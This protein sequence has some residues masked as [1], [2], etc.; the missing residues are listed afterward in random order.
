MNLK[1]KIYLYVDSTSQRCSQFFPTN[2]LIDFSDL[3]QVPT[4]PV[5]HIK[6]GIFPRI[7]EKRRNGTGAGRK[8]KSRDTVSLKFVL[9]ARNSIS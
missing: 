2:F 5:V 3:P 4:T 6:L 8:R 1:K 9:I 7:F